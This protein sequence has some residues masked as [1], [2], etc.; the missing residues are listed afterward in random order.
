MGPRPG[1]I[2]GDMIALRV[3]RGRLWA[4]LSFAIA[5]ITVLVTLVGVA[6]ADTDTTVPVLTDPQTSSI[7]ISADDLPTFETTPPAITARSAILVDA[8][9]GEVLYGKAEGSQ[10]AMASTTKMMTA[11]VVLENMDLGA[12]VTISENA[13]SKPELETWTKAGDVFTVDQLLYSMMVPSHNQAAV[14]LA[15]AFP[16]G[17]SAFVSRMNSKAQEL[18]MTGTRFANPTGLDASGHYSTA[19]DLA[20]LARFAMNDATI[21][22]KFR[23]IVQTREYS[24]QSTD[25]NGGS[26]VFRNS[27]ELLSMYDWVT[28]VKTG[29]TPNAKSCLVAAGTR[30]GISVISVVM[31]VEPH[32]AIFTESLDLL[33]YG[34]ARYQYVTVLEEGAAI[35]EAS[36]PY[37]D[38]PLQFVAKEEIGHELSKGQSLTATVVI[39][40]ALDLPVEAGEVVGRVELSVDGQSAGS[41]DLVASRTAEKPTLGTKIARFFKGLFR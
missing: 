8:V 26:L 16:G 6:W 20:T 37:E 31:G 23:D 1:A 18:G 14:A 36:V 4:V 29:E 30:H 3:R 35:A 32:D 41:V 33:E 7:T 27:N 9:T 2:L 17:Q 22:P 11:V 13:V 38:E 15:E 28:G 25:E 19:A 40:S 21:G 12:Q 39:G 24:L 10:A 34:F 5:L